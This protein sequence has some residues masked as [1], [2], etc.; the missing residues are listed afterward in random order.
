MVGCGWPPSADERASTTAQYSGSSSC[1]A[2]WAS[3]STTRAQF[4]PGRV[5]RTDS[6]DPAA[7]STARRLSHADG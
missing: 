7:S 4:R 1:E 3:R 5:T 2:R 6:V